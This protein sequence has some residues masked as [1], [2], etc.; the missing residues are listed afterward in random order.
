MVFIIFLLYAVFQEFACMLRAL[1]ALLR[2][3]PINICILNY[4]D[5]GTSNTYINHENITHLKNLS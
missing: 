3:N 1:S 5:I 4:M 2:V